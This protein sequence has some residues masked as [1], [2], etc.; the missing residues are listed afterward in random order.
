MSPEER[1]LDGNAAAGLLYEVFGTEITAAPETCANCRTTRPMGAA[2]V[3]ADAPGVVI[4]CPACEGMLI[5]IVRVGDRL[6][7]DLSGIGGLEL[8]V[9]PDSI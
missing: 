5:C 8:L 4:R 6:L 2:H 7:V 1:R 3:Y 9:E